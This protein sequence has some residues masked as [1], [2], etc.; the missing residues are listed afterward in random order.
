MIR[1]NDNTCI[2]YTSQVYIYVM[3]STVL[4]SFQSQI[5]KKKKVEKKCNVRNQFN[6]IHSFLYVYMSVHPPTHPPIHP[7][8]SASRASTYVYTCRYTTLPPSPSPP[9]SLF[10]LLLRPFPFRLKRIQENRNEIQRSQDEISKN[11]AEQGKMGEG[12]G[13]VERYERTGQDR[14]EGGWGRLKDTI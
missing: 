2:L 14:T 5:P 7:S 1:Q 4:K 10:L 3:I 11:G 9:L 6:C 12:G 8:S 13:G